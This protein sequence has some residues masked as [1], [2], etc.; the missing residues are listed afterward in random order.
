MSSVN[1]QNIIDSIKQ[2]SMSPSSIDVL[3]D[4]ERVLDESG[5]YAFLNWEYGE[6][7]SGPNITEYRVE[8]KFWWPENLMPDPAGAL[9]LLGNDIKVTYKKGKLIYPIKIKSE[10]DYRDGAIKKPKLA[11]MKIWFVSIN[12]P[13]Y[14]MNDIK[15]SSNEL[16]DID[17]TKKDSAGEQMQYDA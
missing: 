5:I 2:V 14:L 9:R 15:S 11:K 13:K 6:L 4:F 8:C 16:M 3:C 12:I 17:L 7:C 1:I 10:K